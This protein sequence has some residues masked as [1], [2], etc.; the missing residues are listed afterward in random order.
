[1][2]IH[3]TFLFVFIYLFNFFNAVLLYS[4]MLIINFLLSILFELFICE[5]Y[6]YLIHQCIF[7]L[8]YNLYLLT[9]FF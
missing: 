9:G 5:Y 8:F 3:L 7:V 2:Y 1:M 6:Y 4:Q